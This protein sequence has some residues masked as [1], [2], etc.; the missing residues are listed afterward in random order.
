MQPTARSSIG[1]KNSISS[2]RFIYHYPCAA[3]NLADVDF[4]PLPDKHSQ[5]V[6]YGKL[7]TDIIGI[8]E[9]HACQTGSS[10]Q[11]SIQASLRGITNNLD[12]S[13]T[14]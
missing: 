3:L 4:Q 8:I 12:I 6:P 11:S 10:T 2:K 7:L 9:N 14:V 5:M 13:K 1:K